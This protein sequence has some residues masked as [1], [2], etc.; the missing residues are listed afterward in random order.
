MYSKRRL[1]EIIIKS[2]ALRL[3][4]LKLIRIMITRLRF[5]GFNRGGLKQLGLKLT[6]FKINRKKTKIK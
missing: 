2:L 4:K 1:P 5:L 3:N 6:I